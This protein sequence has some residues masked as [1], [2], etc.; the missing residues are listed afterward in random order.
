MKLIYLFKWNGVLL[1][2]SATC[3]LVGPNLG[4]GNQDTSWWHTSQFTVIQMT[5]LFDKISTT[6][7]SQYFESHSLFHAGSKTVDEK[8]IAPFIEYSDEIISFPV[9]IVIHT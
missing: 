7:E 2:E 8:H 6:I 3:K 9:K 5:N 4:G 1:I